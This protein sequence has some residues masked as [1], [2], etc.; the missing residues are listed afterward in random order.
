MNRA[1]ERLLSL[2]Y[3][4]R[5]LCHACGVPLVAGEGVLCASCVRMLARV[6]LP[7]RRAPAL[8]NDTVAFA[9]SAYT[10]A[11]TASAL[12]KRLKFNAD[13]TAALPLAERMA[14]L[15][16]AF[17]PLR[18]AE[19]CV[20]V[21]V[22]PRRLRQRGYNQAQVLAGAFAD[23]VGVPLLTDALERVHHKRSQV[24]QGREARRQNICGAF[25]VSASGREILAGRRVLLVDDVL[26]TGATVEECARVLREAGAAEVLVLTACRA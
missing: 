15:Y 23:M 2:L 20:A 3:P 16:A 17:A 14:A 5:N 22:H 4:Q 12:V 19:F 8:L 10:Y 7:L 25:A 1:W 18:T 11:G 13:H 6:A 26:T 24:G 9:A 21:P